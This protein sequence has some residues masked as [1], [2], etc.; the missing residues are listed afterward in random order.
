MLP[1]WIFKMRLWVAETLRVWFALTVWIASVLLLWL[2]GGF[3]LRASAVLSLIIA[4][5]LDRLILVD[6]VLFKPK[7]GVLQLGFV[8]DLGSILLDLGIIDH[9]TD[10]DEI[11]ALQKVP[12]KVFPHFIADGF[13]ILEA[14]LIVWPSLQKYQSKF[15]LNVTIRLPKECPLAESLHRNSSRQS[16]G[17][18]PL[19]EFLEEEN[20]KVEFFIEDGYPENRFG[21]WVPKAFAEERI[22]AGG[23]GSACT[24]YNERFGQFQLVVGRFPA[25]LF[26]PRFPEHESLR[27]VE[28]YWDDMRE[29]DKSLDEHFERL[30]WKSNKYSP[31]AENKYMRIVI[32]NHEQ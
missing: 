8:A 17:V 16:E 13:W 20:R 1:Y 28:K 24:E 32:F 12:Y 31:G 9:S 25:T 6:R 3:G 18:K 30:G 4:F 14:N 5:F 10:W 27:R 29:F 22:R 23:F 26:R 19:A 11:V 7:R 2:G 15:E 21:L